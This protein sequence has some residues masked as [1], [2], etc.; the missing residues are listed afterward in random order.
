M[1]V[2]EVIEYVDPKFVESEDGGAA[3]I[4]TISDDPEAES[5]M[6][7]RIQ[8]WDENKE[9]TDI[10]NLIGKRIRVTVEVLD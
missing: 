7:L 4:Y 5:G 6:F 10:N 2:F 8:S 1:K 3:R 9:H